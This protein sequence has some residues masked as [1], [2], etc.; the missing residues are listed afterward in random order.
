MNKI[1]LTT[2]LFLLM[3]TLLYSQ[4]GQNLQLNGL[5][6]YMLV[7]DHNDLDIDAGESFT[8]TMMVKG[9]SFNSYYRFLHKRIAGS[10]AGYQFINS[11]SAGEFGVNLKSTIGTNSGPPFGAISVLDGAWHHL[12]MVVNSSNNSSKIYVD[13]ILNQTKTTSA[14]GTE[15]F[16][17]AIDLF[18]GFDPDNSVYFPGNM[19][20]IRYWSYPMT[21]TDVTNDISAIVV[22]TEPNL[23][24]AWDFENVSGTN[25]PDESGNGHDGVLMGNT[26]INNPNAPITYAQTIL[27][28]T[29]LPVG[30][31][32]DNE[33]ALLLNIQTTGSIGGLSLSSIDLTI[34]NTDIN[35]IDNISIY[36]TAGSEMLNTSVLF[37][38]TLPSSGSLSVNGSQ[39]LQAGNNFFW[40]TYDIA[41]AATEGNFIDATCNAVN[42]GGAIPL[43]NTSSS[44]S[45]LILLEHNTLMSRGNFSSQSYRIPAVCTA[46]DGTIITA[47]D[48]R[49]DNNSD[50]P[51]NI[52]ISIRR[53][54]DGGH[55]WLAPQIIA[56]FGNDGASDPALIVDRNTGDIVCLFASH[57]GLFSS[58]PTNKIRFQVCRSSDNGVTWSVPVEH[59]TS[60]YAPGW[61]AAWVA[62]GS[63]HQLRSGRIVAIVGVRTTSSTSIENYMIYSDDGGVSWEY[64]PNLVATDGN[65]SKIIEL[66]NGDLMVNSR[67]STTNRKVVRSTDGGTS[68]SIPILD[69]I[70]PRCNGDLIRYTSTID[71]FNQSR[72]LFSNLQSTNGRNN[73]HVYMSND[74]ASTWTYS[75]QIYAG[76]S[77]YSSLTILEDGTIGLYYENGEYEAYQM[78]FAR[79]S[80]DWL[81]DGNDTYVPAFTSVDEISSKAPSLMIY[82]NPFEYE[83]TIQLSTNITYPINIEINDVLGKKIYAKKIIKKAALVKI[84][85]DNN[86]PSGTYFIK[87]SNQSTEVT[88]KVIKK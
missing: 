55:T 37:G 76:A 27:S 50:L 53:S 6:A 9:V 30:R 59:S 40:V 60:I 23:L 44:T 84:E 70:D 85:L 22:G 29:T 72:V 14:I 82:P 26:I 83:F 45:R 52:D 28:G 31:G 62:S 25:V 51:G 56:D 78:S 41:D 38:S 15:S 69:L 4:S 35:D 19:D 46:Q 20:D 17:N 13:G 86:L 54:I 33:R 42:I 18:I 39:N 73:L 3:N 8:I 87:V 74:E 77:A 49:I 66:N 32:N 5:D 1:K 68:W 80:L 67:N 64:N 47:V 21:N 63:A 16:A 57:S 36:Y 43:S 71:G 88:K 48:A 10:G 11:N 65:E 81:S 12:A 61:H 79:F 7:Q 24:A 58:T 2:L 34:G 75:K